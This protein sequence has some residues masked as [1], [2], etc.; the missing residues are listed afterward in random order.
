PPRRTPCR[1][2]LVRPPPLPPTYA[3]PARP[4]SRPRPFG[5]PGGPLGP[6]RPSLPDARI[7]LSGSSPRADSTG[8]AVLGRSPG[9][10]AAVGLLVPDRAEAV[11]R[12]GAVGL[13]AGGAPSSRRPADRERQN[14]AGPRSDGTR[15]IERVVPRSDTN[16]ARAVAASHQAHVCRSRRLLRR[17]RPRARRADRRYLRE[18]LPA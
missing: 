2:P 11:P 13:G 1:S 18:R 8:R 3:A 5:Y 7:P 16:P 17:R 15:R 14:P 4:R 9:P 6:T 12:G 10:A